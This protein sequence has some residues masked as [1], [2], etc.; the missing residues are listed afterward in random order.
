MLCKFHVYARVSCLLVLHCAACGS[1]SLVRA[2]LS[3]PLSWT[4]LPCIAPTPCSSS[5]TWSLS[6]ESL[7]CTVLGVKMKKWREMQ[8][9]TLKNFWSGKHEKT[10][11]FQAK[12]TVEVIQVE[13][14]YLE[15]KWG[16]KGTLPPSWDPAGVCLNMLTGDISKGV[17][18]MTKTY[19]MRRIPMWA[20]M[21]TRT[22]GNELGCTNHK[23]YNTGGKLSIVDS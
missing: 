3:S 2:A 1:P 8:R 18:P 14:W 10:Y 11:Y 4:F 9:W 5:H 21:S 15:C 23:R 16:L 6:V 7:G 12:Y 13:I 17:P 19:K 22:H 20:D